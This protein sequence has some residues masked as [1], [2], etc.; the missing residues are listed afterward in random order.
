VHRVGGL[1]A[2]LL[3]CVC[4]PTTAQAAQSARLHVTFTPERLGQATTVEVA[5]QIVAPAGAIPPP[6]TELEVRYPGDL[7]VAVSGLG[8]ATCSPTTLEIFG[9]AVCPADSRM[10]RGSALAEIPIGPEIFH[11][12]ARVAIIRTPEQ[13]GHFAVLF[14]ASGEVPVS[15][16]IAF[17][18]LLLFASSGASIHIDVPLVPGLA[19]GSNVAVVGLHATIGP[20]GLTYYEHLRGGKVISYHPKGVLLPDRCPRGGFPFAAALTFEDGSHAS[21]STTVP[22]PRRGGRPTVPRRAAA[23]SSRPARSR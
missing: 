5:V 7:G 11:E 9:P 18:G 4:L 12:T 19:G 21:A 10:G 22:C 23:R 3:A 1:V 14:Y 13:R 20:R 2:S 8:L 15:A 6:L 16:Q 17:P